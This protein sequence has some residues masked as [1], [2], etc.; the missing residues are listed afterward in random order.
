MMNQKCLKR[1]AIHGG[2]VALVGLMAVLILATGAFADVLIASDGTRWEGTVSEED[3]RYVIVLTNGRNMTFPMS[4]VTEVILT[5]EVREEYAMRRSQMDLTDDAQVRELADLVASAGLSIEYEELVDEA[6]AARYAAAGTDPAALRAVATWCAGYDLEDRAARCT[7]KANTLEFATRLDA[8]TGHAAE[9]EELADWCVDHG[10]Q[11]QAVQCYREAYQVRLE[12]A[13]GDVMA[14][15]ELYHWCT[16]HGLMAE[17]ADADAEAIRLSPDDER[18]M[19]EL[20]YAWDP[21]G[22]EWT[23][24]PA[25]YTEWPFDAQEAAQRQSETAVRLGVDTNMTL[26]LGGGVTMEFV[27]IPAGE[28]IMGSPASEYGR[29]SDEGPTRLV[30]ISKPFYMATC[31][32]T[33]EQYEAIMNSNPSRFRGDLLPVEE[34]TWNDAVEFCQKFA[35]L[36]GREVRLPTEA[37]WEYSCRAGTETAYFWGNDFRL[38]ICSAENDPGS[39]EDSNVPTF[40]QMGLPIDQTVPVASFEPNA[41]GLY[42][43]HGNVWE[44]VSDPYAP[45]VE[46]ETVDPQGPAAGS[47]YTNRGGSWWDSPRT[48]RSA[49][50]DGDAANDS[51]HVLGLRVAVTYGLD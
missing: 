47:E 26:D 48:I 21:T 11:Q 49:N 16:E 35:A 28:F 13:Q 2:G 24:A 23:R 43:M 34:T 1:P 29:D 51:Y 27:L 36:T 39:N 7:A 10:M 22:Q 3:G 46:A 42:D 30:Q 20:G 12:Q 4:A 25:I 44:W 38:G 45:Y 50:R 40:R 14:M 19:Q 18:V 5:A 31:E 32:V 8:A 17:A 41:W 6:F 37:E 15:V 9:L 33:Q